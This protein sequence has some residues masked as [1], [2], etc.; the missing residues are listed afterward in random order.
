MLSLASPTLI[1][2]QSLPTM[3]IKWGHQPDCIQSDVFHIDP[4]FFLCDVST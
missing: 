4:R 3:H 1:R 2:N